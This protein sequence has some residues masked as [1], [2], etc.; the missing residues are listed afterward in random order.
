MTDQ[1]ESLG[2]VRLPA[3]RSTSPEDSLSESGLLIS[4]RSPIVAGLEKE[5]R[6]AFRIRYD[7]AQLDTVERIEAYV[8][9]RP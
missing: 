5:F 2:L 6:S 7:A 4:S 3:N 8:Q 1:T 9:S